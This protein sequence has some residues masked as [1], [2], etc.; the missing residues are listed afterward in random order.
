M[1]GGDLIGFNSPAAASAATDG[2]SAATAQ[3]SKIDLVQFDSLAAES[4]S[5]TGDG[6]GSL[7]GAATA[8][9]TAA[10]AASSSSSVPQQPSS[11][12]DIDSLFADLAPPSTTTRI[13][14]PNTPKT[15]ASSSL[16]DGGGG[17]VP[18]SDVKSVATS[19][20]A[21]AS[22][23]TATT[24][25]ATATGAEEEQPRPQFNYK[26]FFAKMRQPDAFD[27][28]TAIKGF[29]EKNQKCKSVE[30]SVPLLHNFLAEI[31]ERVEQHP[32]WAEA[33][34]W[35]LDNAAEGMEKYVLSKMYRWYFQPANSDDVFKD[36]ALTERMTLLQFVKLEHLEIGPEYHDERR[37]G[38]AQTELIKMDSYKA[39]RDKMICVLNCCKIIT[40]ILAHGKQGRA[41]GADEFLPLLIYVT[42]KANPPNLY[43]NLQFVQRFRTP[44]KLMGEGGYYLTNLFGA[45]QF[46]QGMDASRLDI[47]PSIFEAELTNALEK[48]DAELAPT[49]QAVAAAA[50]PTIVYTQTTTGSDDRSESFGMS[51]D[52]PRPTGAP[53]PP[54]PAPPAVARSGIASGSANGTTTAAATTTKTASSSSSSS[55]AAAAMSDGGGA[56]GGDLLDIDK[57]STTSTKT[58]G[59]PHDNITKS[60]KT[61]R[62]LSVDHDDLLELVQAMKEPAVAKLATCSVEDLGMGDIP[63]LLRDYQRMVK[64]ATRLSA[65][66]EAN[67]GSI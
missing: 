60:K 65:A 3:S 48:R 56:G 63:L 10:G 18:A 54:R 5:N 39:P 50:A 7:P 11:G 62:T 24:M 21:P 57:A 32:L 9:A 36:Q 1:D 44:S 41:A 58:L 22:S 2:S 28:V 29:I 4:N 40:S 53:P 13:I 67:F 25:V 59:H 42:L 16:S 47:D 27:L 66:L 15:P 31:A 38:D 19:A 8:G 46:I 55:A 6:V 35:D 33:S 30:E 64:L 34:E 45:V 20:L 49:Q 52:M 17:S 61:P 26:D 37:M 43:S 23:T 51:T 14:T 12:A